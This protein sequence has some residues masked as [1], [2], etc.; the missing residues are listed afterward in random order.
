MPTLSTA[1]T[2]KIQSL[3]TYLERGAAGKTID[4]TT[5]NA[6][7]RIFGNS[8]GFKCGCPGTFLEGLRDAPYATLLKVLICPGGVHAAAAAG[9]GAAAPVFALVAAWGKLA[10]L[11]AST[12]TNSGNTVIT[13]DLALS[14][15]TAVTGFPP[16]TVSGAQHVTDTAAANDQL[17]L[18][19][20]YLA[21][22]GLTVGRVTVA[23]D[24]GGQ[25]LGPG[26]YNS[27][28]SLAVS[29]GDLILDAQGDPNATW[30]FQIASTLTIGNSVGIDL[31]NGALAS[32]IIWQV[33]SSATI[34]T[35]AGFKGSILALTSI[36]VNTGAT[37]LGRLLARN[38]AVTLL[39][40]LVVA[41]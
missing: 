22:A 9:A 1:D 2:A 18:T 14:P 33:G 7:A 13:G 35:S 10:I 21:A 12:I 24:L 27:T 34:G 19:A 20:A 8:C 17:A 31:I 16:G 38:G 6:L 4:D 28:S 36:S 3:I 41:Q 29:S 40:N 11:G 37:V 5:A 30:V 25:T 15:G 32:N 23:G 26:L 39:G